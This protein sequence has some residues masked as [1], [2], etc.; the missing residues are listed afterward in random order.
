[1]F[2]NPSSLV[3]DDGEQLVPI[4]KKLA[5]IIATFIIGIAIISAIIV[6]ITSIN[7]ASPNTLSSKVN[8][9]LSS[10]ITINKTNAEGGSQEEK[11]SSASK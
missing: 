4:T 3:S 10:S 9:L 2:N 5:S 1:M 6:I 11:H 7:S 8:N